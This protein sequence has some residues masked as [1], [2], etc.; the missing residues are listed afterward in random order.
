[1]FILEQAVVELLNLIISVY[2]LATIFS[3]SCKCFI[4][5]MS[6]LT[7]PSIIKVHVV[8]VTDQSTAQQETQPLGREQQSCRS[9]NQ[10]AAT[11]KHCYTSSNAAVSLKSR[12]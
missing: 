12:M 2:H 9:P 10:G 5:N 6:L 11:I 3:R 7:C 4:F 1:M 8:K